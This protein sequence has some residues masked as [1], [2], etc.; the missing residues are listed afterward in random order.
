VASTDILPSQ[1]VP[2]RV[3]KKKRSHA[4]WVLPILGVFLIG[5]VLSVVYVLRRVPSSSHASAPPRADVS[6]AAIAGGGSSASFPPDAAVPDS[7][8]AVESVPEDSGAATPAKIKIVRISPAQHLSNGRKYLDSGRFAL[9]R[10][11]FEV[12]RRQRRMRAPALVGLAEVDFQLSMYASAEKFAKQAVSSGGGLRAKLVL[13]NIYFKQ[14][15][16]KR[17]TTMYKAVLS[18]G[19]AGKETQEAQRNLAAAQRLSNR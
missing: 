12:V 2:W 10:M 1:H 17:A 8:Q 13:G 16:Y 11:E 4:A 9:A 6:W 5:M 19:Q 3:E 18:Q 15:D 7:A 14:K